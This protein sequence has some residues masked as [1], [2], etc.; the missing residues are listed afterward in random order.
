MFNTQDFVIQNFKSP[1]KTVANKFYLEE[2]RFN[3]TLP[4]KTTRTEK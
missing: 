3:K 4:I 2:N 1:Q